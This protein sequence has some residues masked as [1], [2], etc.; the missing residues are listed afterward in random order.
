M[1]YTCF[2]STEG[3]YKG[4]T[5]ELGVI[6]LAFLREVMAAVL[7]SVIWHCNKKMYIMCIIGIIKCKCIQVSCNVQFSPELTNVS[8]D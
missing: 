5:Y 2:Q 1:A 4:K 7:H 8:I 3:L 6:D